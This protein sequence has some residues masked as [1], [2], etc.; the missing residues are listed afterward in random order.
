MKTAFWA[1]L[2][3]M[4]AQLVIVSLP[5]WQKPEFVPVDPY[6]V[7]DILIE[8]WDDTRLRFHA[9]FQKHD[10]DLERF[11]AV[12]VID[13]VTRILPYDDEDGFGQ[14]ESRTAGL[15]T[16]R[17]FVPFDG[18]TYDAIEF[19]TLHRCFDANAG[20][21]SVNKVFHRSEPPID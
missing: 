5:Y 1:L 20:R 9:T 17:V 3:V 6:T 15:Q 13:T 18:L 4:A 19:R 14:D 8:D 7:T 11:V 2:A 21:Y 16:L 10:C 12:G